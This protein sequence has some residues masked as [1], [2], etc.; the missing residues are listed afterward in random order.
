MGTDKDG[1]EGTALKTSHV[2]VLLVGA[3]LAPKGVA[4]NDHV[5]RAEGNA[6]LRVRPEWWKR[7]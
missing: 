3:H 6:G 7:A 2:Q 5:K 1:V 4:A